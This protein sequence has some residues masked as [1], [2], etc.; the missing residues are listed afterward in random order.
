M[1]NQR[2]NLNPVYSG[3]YSRLATTV[4]EFSVSHRIRRQS[5]FSAT[6]S[7]FDDCYSRKRRL[8]PIVARWRQSHGGLIK[9][10]PRC[11]R[12]VR[13]SQKTA[14]QRRQWPNSATVVL[15]CD[16]LSHFSATVWTGLNTASNCLT[17]AYKQNKIIIFLNCRKIAASCIFQ[18]FVTFILRLRIILKRKEIDHVLRTY[19]F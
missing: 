11:R 14:R 19:C 5:S 15:F 6:V 16:K 8:S 2:E 9:P 1:I 12:K 13:L 7:D 18:N 4:A 3:D 17:S 10:C